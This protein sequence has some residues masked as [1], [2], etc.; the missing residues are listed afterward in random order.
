M[1]PDQCFQKWINPVSAGKYFPWKK[2]NLIFACLVILYGFLLSSSKI[3]F[4]KGSFRNKSIKYFGSR[5]SMTFG[6]ARSAW[7]QT[8]Y[9]GL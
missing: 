4:S 5:S 2:P 1:D 8:V 9:K 3:T 7:V 6:W